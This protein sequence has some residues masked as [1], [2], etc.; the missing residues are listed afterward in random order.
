MNRYYQNIKKCQSYIEEKHLENEYTFQTG[1]YTP[2]DD[3]YNGIRIC[4]TEKATKE[5]VYMTV[6]DFMKN[7]I[8]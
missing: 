1:C 2:F 4:K 6:D 8:K 5:Q 7:V 3:P